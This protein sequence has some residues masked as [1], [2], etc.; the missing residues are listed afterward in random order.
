MRIVNA[1]QIKD[2]AK[3]DRNNRLGLLVQ[4]LQFLP[5]KEK[6]DIW[7]ASNIDFFE[8]QGTKQI[9][10]NAERLLKNYKLAK[11]IIDRRDYI[12][13]EEDDGTDMVETLKFDHPSALDLKFYPIIPNVVNV[14][15]NEFAKRNTSVTYRAVDDVSF[16]EQLDVKKEMVE[17]TLVAKAQQK[18]AAKLIEAGVDPSDPQVQEATDPAKIMELP[19]IQNF[20]NKSYRSQAEE[21]AQ[22]QHNVDIERFRIEEL[23][24]RAFRDMLITDREFWHFRMME[25][26]YEI[27]LW[28]PITTFYHKSP[29]VR[30]ISEGNYVG[31]V[32]IMTASDVLDMYGYL[33]TE[34]EARSIELNYPVKGALYAMQG[35]QNDGSF[36]DP[37]RSHE[38]NTSMPSL[39]YRQ[40]LSMHDNYAYDGDPVWSAYAESEDLQDFGNAYFV[41][42]TTLYWKTQRKVGHLT[43]ITEEG[44]VLEKIVTEDYCITDKPL[45][46]NTFYKNKDA[47]NLVFGEH[48]DW[49]WINEVMGGVK[50]GPNRPSL[51]G[52]N[53]PGGFQPV[54]LGVNKK[55]PGRLKFQFKGD[56][57]LYGCK[58]PVEGAV[59]SD[60]NTRSTAMVDAMKPFQ[61]GYNIV[62]NQ[63]Q[64]ILIDELGTVVL[65]DQNALPQHSLNEDWGKGNYAKAY[66]AMKD[67]QIL[68]LDTTLSNTENNLGFNHYQVLNLEQTQRLLSRVQLA[69]Y[70]KSQAYEVIGVNPQRMGQQM[71][72]KSSATEV[73]QVVTGSYAQT[74]NYFIQHSDYLMPRVHQMR[75]DLAQYY[76]STKP[77]IRLQYV[78][79]IDEKANFEINGTDLLLRDLNVF[80]TTKANHRAILEELK[81]LAK[82]NNSSNASIYDL[83]NII[84]AGS[85]AETD[86]ILKTIEQKAEDAA[87]R[88]QEAKAAENE[89]ILAAEAAEAEKER[90]FKAEEAEKERQKDI[91]VAEIRAAGYAAMMDKNN[92]EVN[93]YEDYM[94]GLRE[95]EQYQQSLGFD[96]QKESNKMSL[97][98]QKLG[99]DRE[100]LN[101]E[102]EKARISLAVAKENKTDAELKAARR[103]KDSN[104]KK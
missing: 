51:W 79:S 59:F 82:S 25:D 99:I 67:F 97:A 78:T 5:E 63:I 71:S 87:R 62:N 50:I 12:I 26:D 16:N 9:S 29:N 21:W 92:N 15:S 96:R 94:K 39:G 34:E 19:E 14:L 66:L 101:V 18:I 95:T 77:S 45:Y 61:I 1:L 42:V 72:Q 46:D 33:M 32:D 43:K 38:W 57:N 91:V 86:K 47:K 27:D 76:Q 11:G 37:T 48:I 20:M 98:Q 73:E 89:A 90:V 53:N 52:M 75:T 8:W 17:Q 40:F 100:K 64:D 56:N 65:L 31:K 10:R 28:N 58:L 103:I 30:Y 54:Y 74:E 88:E 104:K 4:P 93:D 102:R 70:F 69:Q 44:E 80:V 68:P 41:R 36:Y 55:K 35:V 7:L 83:A 24:E 23:E 2:G 13:D 85:I 81:N 60:R 84:K 22:H 3:V 49:M 6:D